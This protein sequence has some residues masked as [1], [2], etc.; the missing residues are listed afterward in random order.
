[1][2]F[3]WRQMWLMHMC[4]PLVLLGL[5]W[6]ANKLVD[7]QEGDWVWASGGER[8]FENQASML[9]AVMY[10]VIA[11]KALEPWDCVEKGGK[12]VLDA[13]LDVLCG[14]V[15]SAVGSK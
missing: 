13:N 9:L 6:V 15:W 7:W 5:L 3:G 4:T 11:Q 12:M 10:T 8:S 1:M 2:D 14:T